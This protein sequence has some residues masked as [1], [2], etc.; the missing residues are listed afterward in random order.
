MPSSLVP[1]PPWPP[2]LAVNSAHMHHPVLERL[3]CL[4][5]RQAVS[6]VHHRSACFVPDGRV[7]GL[8]FDRIVAGN[9]TEHDRDRGRAVADW[10]GLS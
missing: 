9:R 10:C 4:G 5:G 7:G 2:C 1:L 8:C 6:G 3:A